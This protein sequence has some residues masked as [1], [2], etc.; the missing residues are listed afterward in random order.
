VG[1][2][3]ALA[4]PALPGAALAK[5]GARA[6]HQRILAHWTKERIKAAKP[7]DIVVGQKGGAVAPLSTNA[8]GQSWP[9]SGA[10]AGGLITRVTGRVYFELGGGAWVCSGTVVNDSRTGY[11]LV[12]TAGHCVYDQAQGWV[13]Y[14]L[15]IPQA[16]GLPVVPDCSNPNGTPRGCWTAQALLA[17]SRFTSAT[18]YTGTTARYDYGFA[19]VGPGG[20]DGLT[21]LDADTIA[22]TDSAP[23]SMP[24]AFS[25]VARNDQMYAFGYPAAAPY[26][27][28]DLIYCSGKIGQDLFNANATWSMVCNMTGGASGGPW[29]KGFSESTGIGTIG[30]LNSYRYSFSNRMYG[31]KFSSL[32]QSVYSAANAATIGRIAVP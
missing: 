29:L 3:V 17:H 26:N 8:G 18:S 11:S 2:L 32:T 21:E 22:D 14:W 30:S 4:L 24:I 28:T 31:P 25:G 13:S 12:L 19:V 16:D 1:L 6:E 9:T 20:K 7:R 27:G 5:D 15:F 23:D 10:N